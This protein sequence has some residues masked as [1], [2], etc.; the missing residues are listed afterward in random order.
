MLIQN[1]M[2]RSV[3][4]IDANASL[5][6]AKDLLRK[7]NIH[8]LPVIKKEKLVGVVTHG[9][10]K[11]ASASEVVSLDVYELAVLLQKIKIEQIMSHDPVTIPLD[12]TLAE[13]AD[14]FLQSNVSVLPVIARRVQM[15]GIISPS[16]ISRAFLCL[17][18]S[19]RKGIELGLQVKDQRGA[20][21]SITDS[22]RRVRGRIGSLISIDSYAPKGFRQVYIRIYGFDHKKLAKLLP[23]L[24]KIGRLLY[25]IDHQ[26]GSREASASEFKR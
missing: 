12:H 6:I 24:K 4:T 1:W 7:H 13:A 23:D 14:V 25:L 8:A 22:I 10:L 3:V 17:T 18:S 11:R 16:D 5:P 15:V 20:T 26:Q 9:D 2:S 19:G 21:L